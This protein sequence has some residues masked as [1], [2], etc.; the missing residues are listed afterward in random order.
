[1]TRRRLLVTGFGPFPTVPR[2]PSAAAAR[3][4]ASSRRLKLLEVEAEALILT[5]AYATL[6]LELDPALTAT[7]DAVLMIG[8]AARSRPIRIE[9]RATARRSTLFP[10]VA[11]ERATRPADP[12]VARRTRLAP[13]KARNAVA[14]QGLPVRLSRDAGRYLCNAAYFRALGQGSAT[15]FVHIPLS[16][17]LPALRSRDGATR[18]KPRLGREDRLAA[19]LVEVALLLLRE[20]RLQPAR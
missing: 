5:T 17:S 8:V 13:V 19:A 1:M 7:P 16:R 6:P 4:V 18:R 2:N 10:D 3:A 11:G 20:K 15:L 12:S 14:R 9:W